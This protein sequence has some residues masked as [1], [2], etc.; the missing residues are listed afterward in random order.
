[1]S[2]LP[3]SREEVE[4]KC[5][6]FPAADDLDIDVIVMLTQYAFLDGFDC[7]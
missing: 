6:F 5:Q 2:T 1:M 7:A 4:P 3:P